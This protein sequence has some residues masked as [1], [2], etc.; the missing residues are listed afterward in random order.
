MRQRSSSCPVN[1]SASSHNGM[2]WACAKRSAPA[3]AMSAC[4]VRSITRRASEM[5][6]RTCCTAATAPLSSV[7]PSMMMASSSTS[8]AE[9]SHAP[10]PASKRR[11]IFQ[12]SDGGFHG[13]ERRSALLQD[14]PADLC[15]TRQPSRWPVDFL[16]GNIPRAAVDDEGRC[17][18]ESCIVRFSNLAVD[19][20][21]SVRRSCRP[22]ND[23]LVVE[24]NRRR[25]VA[26]P[27]A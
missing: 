9:F 3:P 11:I 4:A 23:I 15:G 25:R 10:W 26:R 2:P 27:G 22:A 1:S 7:A 16:V 21:R 18:A 20:R 24:R 12:R 14:R 13:V 19:A 5:G 8:P 6:L 17:E